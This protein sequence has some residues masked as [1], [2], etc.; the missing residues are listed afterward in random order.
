MCVVRKHSKAQDISHTYSFSFLLSFI[1]IYSA[2]AIPTAERVQINSGH[3]L[4]G[5]IFLFQQTHKAAFED[6]TAH[7]KSLY[8]LIRIAMPEAERFGEGC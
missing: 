4:V 8:C 5:H 7:A 3:A 2:Y 6:L 1:S